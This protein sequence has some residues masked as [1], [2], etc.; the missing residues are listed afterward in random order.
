[1]PSQN[2]CK[3]FIQSKSARIIATIEA[4]MGSSRLPGKVLKPFHQT[5]VLDFMVRRV[6]HSSLV[7]DIVVATSVDPRDREIAKFCERAA[8]SCFRGSEADVLDRV[9][10]AAKSADATVVVELTGDCPL[11]DA[12][13]IDQMIMGFFVNDVDYHTNSVFRSY[14]DGMDVQIVKLSALRQAWQDSSDVYDREH[15]TPYIY[16][17][18]HLFKISHQVASMDEFW[19]ELGLTLDEELDYQFLSDLVKAVENPESISCRDIIAYLKRRDT[20]IINAA[21]ARKQY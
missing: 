14:P 4:R 10:S 21:V 18:P 2:S 1:M 3:E 6:R 15:V 12:R 16:N 19:P 17:N 7:D 9:Y 13:I 11:I 20:E 8:I 5:N